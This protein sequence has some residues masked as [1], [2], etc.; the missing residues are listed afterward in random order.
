VHRTT[1][2]TRH[3]SRARRALAT[4][5][6]AVGAVA[7]VSAFV[8]SSAGASAPPDTT[9]GAPSGSS[10]S[11]VVPPPSGDLDADR[12]AIT[13]AV[14]DIG[15][16]TGLPFQTD[17]VAGIVDRLPDPD[18][19]LILQDLADSAA[20]LQEEVE[21]PDLTIPDFTIPDL[22]LPDFTLPDLTLPDLSNITIPDFDE[23]SIPDVSD[24]ISDEADALGQELVTCIHGDADPALVEQALSALTTAEGNETFDAECASGVLTAFPEPM[25]QWIIDNQGR[26]DLFGTSV[27]DDVDEDTFYTLGGTLYSCV[28]FD[29]AATTMT[30]PE[31]GALAPT[32]TP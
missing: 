16:Y 7:V 27:P 29:A 15:G 31:G 30:V 12:A 23:L 32:S 21:I 20:S 4:S 25:L 17:C 8:A 11:I 9:P 2:P 6:T 18:V 22:E 14:V 19:P 3:P 1:T 24:E 13:D 5:I 28:D 26:L 10:P